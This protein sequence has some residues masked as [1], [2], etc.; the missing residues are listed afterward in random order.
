VNDTMTADEIG[1]LISAAGAAPSMH[2]TQPW[3]FDIA[4]PVVDVQLDEERT[5]P[6]ED[7]AGR[8]IRAGLGAATFNLRVAAAMLGHAT[9]VALEP[10]PARPEVVARVFLAERNGR[11][12]LAELYAGLHRRHT[13]RG[14]ML[15]LAIPPPVRPLLVAAARV[16]GC[17]WTWLG[18]DDRERLL[19]VLIEADLLERDEH[20]R[21]ERTAWIGGDRP[22]DGV[23]D[24]ALGARPRRY[25][26]AYR[27]L[28]AGLPVTGRRGDEIEPAPQL[29]VLSTA[30]DTP[31]D[32]LRAG[33]ALQHALLTASS[34]DLSASFVNQALEHAGTRA[35]VG[36][37]IKPR[38]HP[39]LVI[40]IG[41]PAEPSAGHASRRPWQDLIGE[42]R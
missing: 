27:D 19:G 14:R 34:F 12:P 11:P 29:A 18:A 16:E 42:Q 30:G 32:W 4:G 33:M 36:E 15:S 3:R 23:P 5:L 10:D 25:P 21:A 26:V 6:A 8:M 28:A 1:I 7:P 13:Y 38:T 31:P 22:H 20:R 9:T 37:L 35:L 24:S 2:N 17:R 40:R 41:Y 39:Q